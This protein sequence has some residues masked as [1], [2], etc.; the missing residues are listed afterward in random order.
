M[1]RAGLGEVVFMKEEEIGRRDV[2][3]GS[4]MILR[5]QSALG[6]PCTMTTTIGSP[7]ARKSP[8]QMPKQIVPQLE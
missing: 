3:D 2:V 7:F 4:R 6:A 1:K 8:K 5:L